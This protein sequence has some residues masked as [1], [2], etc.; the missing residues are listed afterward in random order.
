MSRQP[1]RFMGVKFAFLAAFWILLVF[2]AG[3]R[4]QDE[5]LLE[6][7]AALELMRSNRNNAAFVI[8]DVRTSGE[9][10]QGY[11]EGAVLLDYHA[12]DFRERFAELDRSATILMYCRSGNRSSH[13]LRMADELGF[14]RV[15]DLRGGIL[16]WK[17]AGLP[18][19][20]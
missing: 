10:R 6:P 3:C 17:E 11:I 9:F 1:T 4:T 18:L 13:A 19:V 20:R 5:R 12:A 8:L 14:E 7:T 2:S 15:Y 16:A